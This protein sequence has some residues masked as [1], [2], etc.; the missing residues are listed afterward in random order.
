MYACI[1][2]V[3]MADLLDISASKY[4]RKENKSCEFTRDE[5]L[6]IAKI[7]KLDEKTMLT[8]WMADK[9]YSLLKTDKELVGDA[10]KVVEAHLDDYDYCVDMPYRN[11]S[12]SSL[13]E[14]TKH[15]KNK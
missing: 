14:R 7:L 11:Q 12:F 8:Y 10:L 5:V 1:T 4:L 6:K 2:Q 13:D 9:V 15:H 3:Q